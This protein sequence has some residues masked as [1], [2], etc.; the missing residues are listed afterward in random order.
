MAINEK[1]FGHDLK[2]KPYPKLYGED[3]FNTT[4]LK[5]GIKYLEPLFYYEMA[6]T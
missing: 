5:P 1:S 2:L 4:F 3:K 6:C